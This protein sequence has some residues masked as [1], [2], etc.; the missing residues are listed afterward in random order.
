MWLYNI[1][2]F[3]LFNKGD[4]SYFNFLTHGFSNLKMNTSPVEFPM[5]D[6]VIANSFVQ[7]VDYSA[8]I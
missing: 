4:G 7:N 2:L 1:L 5:L 3:L 8:T 6:S